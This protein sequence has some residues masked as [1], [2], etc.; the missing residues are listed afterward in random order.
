MQLPHNIKC[1]MHFDNYIYQGDLL[2]D[3]VRRHFCHPDH[4]LILTSILM[5][6]TLC[7]V[8]KFM[9]TEMDNVNT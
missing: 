4:G 2:L 9:Y 1:I 7:L 8:W 3:G 6:E 5:T